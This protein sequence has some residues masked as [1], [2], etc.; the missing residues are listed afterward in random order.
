MNIAIGEQP[1]RE[2]ELASS[3]ELRVGIFARQ[4]K[5]AEAGTIGML[6]IAARFEHGRHII[7]GLRAD[8]GGFFQEPLLIGVQDEAVVGGHV[9]RAGGEAP[10][11]QAARMNGNALT[12]MKDFHQCFGGA[13]AHGLPHQGMRNAVVVTIEDNVII[14]VDF[15]IFPDCELVGP[16]GKGL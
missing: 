5:Q 8:F 7:G 16:F 6:G 1:C 15:G 4:A 13:N 3:F 9:L 10:L 2:Q 14:D 11:E 12:M